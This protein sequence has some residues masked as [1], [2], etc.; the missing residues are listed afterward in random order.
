MTSPNASGATDPTLGPLRQILVATDFS[1][2]ATLAI[3]RAEEIARE[4]G[5]RLHL[6]HVITYQPQ[7]MLGVQPMT[8]PTDV[9]DQVRQ[10]SEQRLRDQADALRERGLEVEVV[11]TAGVPGARIVHVADRIDADLVVVGTRGLSGFKHLLLGSTAEA[12]ARWSHRPVLSVHPGSESSLAGMKRVVLP[13]LLADETQP[14]VDLATRLLAHG[15]SPPELVLV[16]A[17]HLPAPLR[18]LLEDIAIDRVGFEAVEKAI[19]EELEPLCKAME[20]AGFQTRLAV[21][22]G[23]PA[24]VIT[25]TA[26]REGADLILIATH[27]RHGL[28]RM[29]LG[30]TTERVIQHAHCPVLSLQRRD[31]LEEHSQEEA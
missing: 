28:A 17:D 13:V 5:A 24:T 16:H 25:E 20:A 31:A 21:A 15:E 27:G 8:T 26:E 10:V 2:V 30:S 6:V 23:E 18:P 11:I 14:L 29:V 19:R 22:E 1:D 7:P 9:S 12:V 3:A 4:H